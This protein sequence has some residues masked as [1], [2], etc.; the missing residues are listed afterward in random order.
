LSC[1]AIVSLWVLSIVA[2]CGEDAATGV[3]TPGLEIRTATVGAA[4]GA[5]GYEVGIDGAATRPI[6]ATDTLLLGDIAVGDH[7]VTLAGLAAECAVGGEN[8]RHV[9]VV[10]GSTAAVEFAVTCL[11][12]AGR[13]EVTTPTTGPDPDA[14]G[15]ELFLDGASAGSLGFAATLSL[16]ALAVGPHTVALAGLAPNC[17]MI[18]E[19]PVAIEI[20]AGATA[21]ARFDVACTP[22][23]GMLISHQELM[24][25]GWHI[26]TMHPDGSG[27]R[28]LVGSIGIRPSPTWSPDGRWIAFVG[29]SMSGGPLDI[30]VIDA[31]GG[32]RTVLATEPVEVSGL[33]WSPDGS[34]LAFASA[35]C[36]A[37]DVGGNVRIFTINRDGTGRTLVAAGGSPA[38]S[39]DGS[40]IA[41]E[42]VTQYGFPLRGSIHVVAADGSGE[43]TLSSPPAGLGDHDPRWSP[44]GGRVAFVR[45]TDEDVDGQ[46]LDNL[47]VVKPDGTNPKQLTSFGH[48]VFPGTVQGF[49]WSPDGATLAYACALWWT[50]TD[51]CLIQ[52]D[53]GSPRRITNG[54]R[55]VASDPRW[56]PDGARILFTQRVI[57][58]DAE[59][60]G[61]VTDPPDLAVLDVAG[62]GIVMLTTSPAED[63][64][65]RWRP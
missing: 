3:E 2:A 24:H 13:L 7:A 64:G 56:S 37:C 38:W 36:S 63:S 22:A 32:G 54:V 47:W 16:D 52:P 30:V 19:N 9:S 12:P 62:G 18:G 53:G 28:D 40:L 41:F 58:R 27:L 4:A 29:R 15:Y 44:D 65:G 5:G 35:V 1:R 39:P 42:T 45:S 20:A 61:E 21:P 14:D 10:A 6:G 50:E 8:P 26:L 60:A 34:K 49:D 48:G 33:A 57:P 23:P 43:R 25:D 46:I 11:P 17:G 31:D 51:L 55:R 59:G